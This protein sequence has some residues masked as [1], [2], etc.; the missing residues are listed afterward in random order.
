MKVALSCLLLLAPAFGGQPALDVPIEK[1]QLSNGMRVVLSRDNSVPVVAVYMLYG[2]GARSEEKGRTGFAHL[3]EHMMFEGSANAPKGVMDKLVNSNGGYLNGSTHPDFT[4]YYEV[5]PSNKLPVA[6]WLEADRMR[7]LVIDKQ[8]LDNQKEAVKQER[9]LSFDNQP[10][11]TAIVDRFPQLAFRNWSNAH[12]IIGSFEDLEAATVAD[13]SKFFHTFYA[14]NNAVMVICGD[15]RNDEARRLIETYFSDIAAQTQPRH[16]DRAEPAQAEPRSEVY[17]D[18]LARVPAVAISFPGPPRRSSGYYA[19]VLLDA[20]FTGG[21]SSRFQQ[22]LVKGR[23]SAVSFEA[24]LGW[25]MGSPQDYQE[26]GIY[27]I[28][29]MHKPELKGVQVAAQVGEEIAAVRKEGV[30][31]AEL[32]RARTLLR[33]SRIRSLQRV[34][35]RAQLLGQ[36][37]LFD[38][39]PELINSE[40][41]ELAKVT[42]EQ[43]REVAKRYLD[44]KQ[45]SLLEIV[46]APAAGG[47]Q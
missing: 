10:Y 42:P 40:M 32:G 30:S 46:P 6:L 35:T 31:A 24:N 9:R 19:M 13:V 45:R 18:P 33:A 25:P 4:D 15:I 36:Y 26:P 11:A 38:G 12:S 7:G 27:G 34:I 21:D 5:L 8:H 16:P 39:R 28:F 22:N 3:F 47:K 14:P 29:V 43:V 17:K 20:V 1:F 41:D 23:Q 37:E 2:V 44:P